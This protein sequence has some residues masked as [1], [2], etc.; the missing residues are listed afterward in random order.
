MFSLLLGFLI[1]LMPLEMVQADDVVE[2]TLQNGLTILMKEDHRAPIV[3][4]QI[5]YR[6]GSS[7]ELTGATGVSHVLEHMMFKGTD[8][9][10]AGEIS[11][12]VARYGGSENAFTGRDYTGYYQSWEKSRLPLSFAIESNRM[13]HLALDPDEFKKE[14]SVVMEERRLRTDDSPIGTAFERL[15]AT[16]FVSS[17][18]QSPIIGWMHDLEQLSLE[19]TQQWYDRWYA[20][21]NATVVVVGDIKPHDV[22]ALAE[23]Y[24]GAIPSKPLPLLPLYKEMPS[25]G[26]K[27]IVVKDNLDVP[28]LMMGF[29][30]PSIKT[31]HDQEEVFALMLLMQLLDGG[32]SA[33]FETNLVRERELAASIGTSYDPLARGDV[34]FLIVG[35]PAQGKTLD[36]LEA[37]I[38]EQIELMASEGPTEEE[39]K[40]AIAQMTASEIFSQDSIF[41]QADLLG[42]LAVIDVDWRL[43]Q[44]WIERISAVDNASVKKVVEKY[45]QRDRL[46]LVT[47]VPEGV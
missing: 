15:Y 21:N 5:W 33:R 28:Q 44:S 39:V 8:R 43:S 20:P 31:A 18:Y 25:V 23:K 27:R 29:T 13:E 41:N 16:A 30:V 34:L 40:R 36:A 19:L 6:I 45:L 24:F 12:L 38:F 14:K 26:E 47:L 35:S 32:L 3:V 9:F 10:G 17:P 42:R 37:G 46:T 22:I 1:T 4:S 7:F 11:D 2:H